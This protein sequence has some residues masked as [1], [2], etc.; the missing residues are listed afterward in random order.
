MTTTV[1][2]LGVGHLA[3]YL[4]PGLLRALAPDALLLSPRNREKAAALA[5][6][7]GIPLAAD[8]ADLVERSDVVLLATRPA[9]A[10]DAIA[11]LPWRRGQILVSLCAG[12][13][14]AA[15]AAAAPA[16]AARAMPISA[17]RIGQSPTCL[18]PDSQ[19]AR[20]VLAPLG[21][22]L[23]L[24]DEA[25]FEAA[26]VSAAYYGW[27]HALIGEIANWTSAAG[28]PPELARQLIGQT[29]AAAAGMVAADGERP[30]EDLVR[31]LATPGGITE[32][33]LK[34]LDEAGSFDDW[35]AACDA[36]L[37]KLRGTSGGPA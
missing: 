2:L 17:A 32:L 33:G 11:G 34:H 12:V 14:I 21:P 23:L 4:V 30:I 19:P 37:A 13:P 20:E 31:S 18:Y 22:V 3:E 6:I 10:P 26:T 25:G 16:S 15:L 27:V 35:R 1:G 5:D 24:P 8:N 36:V 28:V 9:Q 29:T 7:H